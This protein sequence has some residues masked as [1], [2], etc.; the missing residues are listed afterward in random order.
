MVEVA[1]GGEGVDNDS[2]WVVAC[3]RTFLEVYAAPRFVWGCPRADSVPPTMGRLP[4]HVQPLDSLYPL[5]LEPFSERLTS[6]LGD[7]APR[8]QRAARVPCDTLSGN[9]T[10]E[11]QASEDAATATCPDSDARCSDLTKSMSNKYPMTSA[12]TCPDD[13]LTDA[14]VAPSSQA[15]EAAYNEV[16]RLGGGRAPNSFVP[17]P[18]SPTPSGPHGNDYAVDCIHVIML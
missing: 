3:R 13:A 18:S 5:R 12:T 8:Q 14:D 10:G 16:T 2:P 6:F 7:A 1:Q 17:S 4:G 15:P 9:A 11:Q